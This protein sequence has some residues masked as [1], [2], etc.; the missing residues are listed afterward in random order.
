MNKN[1]QV[2]YRWT[3][4]LEEARFILEEELKDYDILACDFEIAPR[5]SKEEVEE[6]KARLET[7]ANLSWEERRQLEQM[8]A[9]T[10]LSHPS[11]TQIT[12][13]SVAWSESQACVL[14]ALREPI[15][16]YLLNFLVTTH[17][18]LIW[19]NFGFD[20]RFL[21][22]HTNRLPRNWEDTLLL[23]KAYMNHAK[24]YKCEVGLKSLEGHNYGEWA[25]SKDSFK[26]DEAYEEYML[27]YAATDACATYKLYTEIM[28]VE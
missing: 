1:I 3:D 15:R 22:Y 18:T 19:H 10:G 12:H 23:A 13:L 21:L 7:E 25:I 24:N 16:A 4:C 14:I 9:T 6:A 8:V 11:L 27:K 20:A 17:K 28:E 2:S 5:F 26:L